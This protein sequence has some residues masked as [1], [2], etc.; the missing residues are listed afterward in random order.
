MWTTRTGRRSLYKILALLLSAL[1]LTGLIAPEAQAAGLPVVISAA[2]DYTHKTVTITGQNFGSS[3]TVTLDAMTFP[4]ITTGNKQIVADF[5]TT[6]PPSSL[7]PGTYFL[8]VTFRNQFPTIFAVDIGANGPQG[9]QGVA[10]P[11]GPQGLQGTQ[12]LTGATGAVGLMGPPGPMGPAGAVGAMGAT[13]AKGPAGATGTQGSQGPQGIAGSNGTNGAGAPI[14]TASDTVV[15]YQ[16]ALVCS[17]TLPRYMANGDG[18]LT[19]RRTGLMWEIKTSAC[20]GE[21]TCYQNSYYWSETAIVGDGSLFSQF[22]ATLNG[23]DYSSP[24]GGQAG[25]P[26]PGSPTLD[27]GVSAGPGSCFAN[28]CD[29][30]IP[31]IA[32]LQTIIDTDA[33][34]CGL[35]SP[36]I[37]PNFGPTQANFYWS[38]SSF[39][40]RP[41]TAWV[42]FF[43]NG[44][45]NGFIKTLNPAAARAVRGA[46]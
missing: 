33:P 22:L 43:G 1:L 11:A 26:V 28:H 8:T 12:G 25:V 17:S 31:T 30:R 21:V 16:G 15:S 40:G 42:F 7:T 27:L 41:V 3:P 23:G 20:G 32:E 6:S 9:P 24:W 36:C 35:G 5:P 38:S 45:V 2:V 10:G 4:T 37:D 13:G 14:C 19:D 34:G 46:Q 18:T 44:V 29:W 39:A